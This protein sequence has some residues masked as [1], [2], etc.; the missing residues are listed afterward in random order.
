MSNSEEPAHHAGAAAMEA[1]I[2]E[3]LTAFDRHKDDLL[4][5][6]KEVCDR[7]PKTKPFDADKSWRY[8]R[9]RADSDHMDA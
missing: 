5:I 2:A 9:L 4:A 8:V 6:L 1:A 7:K 3:R